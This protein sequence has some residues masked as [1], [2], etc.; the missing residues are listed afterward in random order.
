MVMM[1]VKRS[2]RS[3]RARGVYKRG[4]ED[5]V[6]G[7]CVR[8]R[9]I[10]KD[11]EMELAVQRNSI[12]E[13]TAVALEFEEEQLRKED[14]RNTKT[15]VAENVWE[16]EQFERSMEKRACDEKDALEA[17]SSTSTPIHDG[18]QLDHPETRGVNDV[19]DEEEDEEVKEKEEE[20]EEEHHT[21]TSDGNGTA[22]TVMDVSPSTAAVPV[23]SFT[24]TALVLR[25]KY[26][27]EQGMLDLFAELVSFTAPLLAI[28]ISGPVLSLVDAA[29]V[30]AGST[31]QLA[32]LGPATSISDQITYLCSFLAIA[33]TNML[34][35]AEGRGDGK[36]AA[37]F[38]REA[39]ALSGIVGIAIAAAGWF[40]AEPLLRSVFMTG[41]GD[42]ALLQPASEYL[43]V[44]ALVMPA[45][46][47]GMVT[48]SAFLAWKRPVYPLVAMVVS[49]IFNLG[50]DIV[51][52]N[53]FGMGCLGAALATAAAQVSGTIFLMHMLAQ[54]GRASNLPATVQPFAAVMRWP[55]LRSFSRFALLAGPI[56]FILFTKT[57]MYGSVVFFTSSL[58]TE[59]L[60]AHVATYSVFIFF[61]VIGDSTN[62][63]A[64]AYLPARLH[65]TG[66]VRK[67]VTIL[68]CVG[69]CVGVVASLCSGGVLYAFPNM[70]T[71]NANVIRVIRDTVPS[72][73]LTMMFHA[74]G[75]TAE[76]MLMAVR[77]SLSLS[78]CLCL[79]VFL[80]DI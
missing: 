34:A 15:N 42:L 53:R 24:P 72:I 26:E 63:A 37:K 70:F 78:P 57:L 40:G 74:M 50:G 68:L 45:C 60:A 59:Q 77:L 38:L 12:E 65:N 27:T 66:A 3:V 75:I 5:G 61:A 62:Q 67:L 64:Q 18:Q 19:V 54:Q 48:Q 73:S 23:S 31:V 30:G 17:T 16:L 44:R 47:V 6:G 36:T 76:G 46:L 13:A 20:E 32:A 79:L 58:G 33:T 25:D 10:A 52:C 29:V 56:C 51:L 39:L 8:R 21:S 41:G 55:G 49:A 35:L 7:G 28:W 14:E 9:C 71:Q 1:V 43:K 22:T 2:V 80:S 4:K 11:I 69:L